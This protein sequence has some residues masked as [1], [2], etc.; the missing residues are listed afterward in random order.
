VS[1]DYFAQG[2][3]KK[4]KVLIFGSSG[5][6]GE[7][8]TR[9]LMNDFEVIT[10][11]KLNTLDGYCDFTNSS[12]VT[13]T[14][15]KVKPD[16]IINAAAFTDVDGAESETNRPLVD[17]V[18]VDS[19]R[20]LSEWALYNDALLIHFSTD[21]V[22]DG[23]KGSPYDEDNAKSPLNYYGHTKSL[24]EDVV[25]KSGCKYIVF[26]ISWLY[27]LIRNN[28]VL[29]MLNLAK[30]NRSI[31][32]V[33]DQF[34][35]PTCVITVAKLTNK[36]CRDYVEKNFW[37]GIYHLSDFGNCS[38]IEFAECIFSHALQLKLIDRKPDILPVK[39]CELNSAA[40]RPLDTRLN[41]QRVQMTFDVP[42]PNWDDQVH[43]TMRHLADKVKND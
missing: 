17:A 20:L 14:L 15:D 29:T 8:L 33:S 2:S 23:A 21:Y 16:I 3:L 31:N 40:Q 1:D 13:K 39:T 41:I 42:I 9:I 10:P 34:G 36:V 35:N 18:N 27:S 6:L 4:I 37:P 7:T 22:F 28:F 19:P 24:S 5:Q 38:R 43:E 11:P 26:R 32:L 25:A 30:N 12:S